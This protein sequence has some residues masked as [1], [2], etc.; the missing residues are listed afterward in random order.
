[1]NEI[2][3]PQKNLTQNFESTQDAKSIIEEPYS[4]QA[5]QEIDDDN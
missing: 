1:M 3:L 5:D 2:K 4:I